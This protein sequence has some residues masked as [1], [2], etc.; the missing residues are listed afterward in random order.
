MRREIEQYL[1]NCHM[2]KW[3][4]ASWDAY[5]NFFQPLAVLERLWFNLTID[6]VV[7]LLKNQVF[8]AILMVVDWFS[9][10]KHYIPCTRKNNSSDVKATARLFLRH[11]WCFHGFLISF[12]SNWGLQFTLKMWD[13]L[14]KLL[15]IKVKFF[16]A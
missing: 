7:G 4:K 15:K 12:T 14:C 13:L 11:A 2:C 6:F 3:V 5:N 10:E 8:D 1:C 16:T 9:K